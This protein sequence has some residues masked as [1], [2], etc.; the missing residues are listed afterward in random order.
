MIIEKYTQHSDLTKP[1]GVIKTTYT[2]EPETPKEKMEFESFINSKKIPKT[3]LD[4][5]SNQYEKI[6]GVDSAPLKDAIEKA[7]KQNAEKEEAILKSLEKAL[8]E[9]MGYKFPKIDNTVK[10]NCPACKIARGEK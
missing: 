10:Y 2:V 1:T 7:A 6:F 4:Q 9:T 3:T 5:F 8:E